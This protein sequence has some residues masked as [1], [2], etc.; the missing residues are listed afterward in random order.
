MSDPRQASRMPRLWSILT[1]VGA[2]ETDAEPRRALGP[3]S[4]DLGPAATPRETSDETG[5][6]DTGRA[7]LVRMLDNLLVATVVA[8]VLFFVLRTAWTLGVAAQAVT[9]AQ[10][11]V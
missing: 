4:I 8:I 2:A 5:R 1:G 9:V 11:A 7:R 3:E 10:G 6:P